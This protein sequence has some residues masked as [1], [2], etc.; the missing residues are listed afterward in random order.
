[1]ETLGLEKQEDE[2]SSNFEQ[3]LLLELKKMLDI[4]I[5]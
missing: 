4:D 2:R 3:R 1:M 5:S